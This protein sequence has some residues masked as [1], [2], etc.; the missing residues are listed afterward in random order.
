VVYPEQGCDLAISRMTRERERK[1][2]GCVA[3]DSLLKW[4]QRRKGREG[5]GGSFFCHPVLGENV[6]TARAPG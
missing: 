2:R 6:A 1:M 4:W 3:R 5:K